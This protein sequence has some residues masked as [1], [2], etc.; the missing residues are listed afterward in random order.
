MKQA[1]FLS[2]L[3]ATLT[4]ADYRAG[5][6]R[7]DITPEG[8]I[9]LSGYAV[10]K[11]PSEGVLQKL[12]AKALALDDNKGGRVVIVTT[13][14]IGLPR[15]VSDVVGA[16]VEKQ[17]GLARAR[18]LLNSSHTHTGP[19]IRPNL[20]LMYD[21]D[22]QNS[23]AVIVYTEKLTDQL[24]SVVGAALSDLGPASV[25]YG[26]GEVG[27]A[28][29]RRAFSPTGVKIGVNRSGN[30][31][32]SVPV[33]RVAKQDGS[34]R[35]VIFGYA[36]HNTTLT[37]EHYQISGD[38]AGVA[39]AEIEKARPGATAMF[40][41]LCG[42]DQNPNPRGQLEHV[43]QHGGALAR[44]VGRVLDG[45]LETVSGQIRAAL[46]LKDIPLAPHSRETFETMQSDSDVYKQRLAKEML[47]MYDERRPIRTVLYP[48]QALRLGRHLAIVALGGEV[49]V[50]YGLWTKSQFPKEK[51]IVAGYSND[52]MCYIPTA[53]ILQEGGYEAVS[54]MVYYGQPG[55]FAPEVEE[56]IHASIRDVM[57]RVGF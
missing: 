1:V 21:L 35:A 31:D 51:V 53:K 30:V 10:R 38:Y 42:A 55:P 13:D 49:V 25:A 20:H 7:V 22:E 3:A 6:G 23:R 44:E 45:K 52:V 9:W 17:F 8:P 5:V 18:L 29:N 50:D 57:K 4:A 27:F 32:H 11:K 2:F 24:V 37:G 46:Q 43:H 56:I 15:S 54:S 48:V 41:M 16:R 14:I 12:W 36:C 34:L 33:L 40:L 26:S 28:V 47:R 19:V 39:Q